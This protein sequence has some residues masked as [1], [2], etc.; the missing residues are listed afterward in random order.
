M[1]LSVK[2]AIAQKKN[3]FYIGHRLILPF[4]CQILKVIVDS[5]IFTELVGGKNLKLYQDP[6][7]TSIYIRTIGKLNNYIDTYKS[8]KIIVAEWDADLTDINT[9]QKLVCE[10]Q[11]GHEVLIGEPDEDLLFI[12]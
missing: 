1:A 2:E 4:K 11:D 12:E 10:I 8:I 5:E 7:N 9:H 6:Q 3:G